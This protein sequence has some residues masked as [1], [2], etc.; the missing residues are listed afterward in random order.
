MSMD[1]WDKIFLAFVGFVVILNFGHIN[2][3]NKKV[4]KI[5]IAEEIK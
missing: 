4:D 1:V 5:I 3:L 2:D